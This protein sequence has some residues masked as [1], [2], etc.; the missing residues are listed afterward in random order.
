MIKCTCLNNSLL[1]ESLTFCHVLP[2]VFRRPR[3]QAEQEAAADGADDLPPPR[4]SDPPDR[5][6]H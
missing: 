4:H 5:P 3:V 1:L 6:H 2:G